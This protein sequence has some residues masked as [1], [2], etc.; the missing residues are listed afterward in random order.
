[1]R[2]RKSDIIL[3]QTGHRRRRVRH[4]LQFGALAA[5]IKRIPGIGSVQQGRHPPGELLGPPHA[6][7]TIR[8]IAVQ[9]RFAAGLIIFRKASRQPPDIGHRQVQS[10][11]SCRGNNVRRISGKKH[12]SIPHGFRNEAAHSGDALLRDRADIRLPSIV[13]SKTREEFFPDPVVR[14]LR[15]VFVRSTLQVQARYRIRTHAE[16]SE[17]V[18]VSTVDEFGRGWRR[19]GKN[20]EP[21]EGINALIDPNTVFRNR[22]SADAVK[23]IAPCDE[24][25]SDLLRLVVVSEAYLRLV[26][27]EVDYGNV[28]NL[29]MQRPSSS[30]A[31]RDEILHDFV[32]AVDRDAPSGQCRQIDAAAL[33]VDVDGDSVMEQTFALKTVS[34][35]AFNHEIDRSLLDRKSTRLN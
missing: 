9:Q 26:R 5:A 14:P 19:V 29:E 28:S 1:M 10:L 24:V 27:L 6:L 7:Q 25:A 18:G 17:A 31:S 35:T 3:R 20:T 23:T 11:G 8:R 15:K 12:P 2:D 32:L 16:Q 34:D 22:R 33:T 13:A 4:V 21:P 30:H